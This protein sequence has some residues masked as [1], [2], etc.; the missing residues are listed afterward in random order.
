MTSS[1]RA[2]LQELEKNLGWEDV[3]LAPRDL[4]FLQFGQEN[5]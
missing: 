3:I 2:A 4:G 1:G 5:P